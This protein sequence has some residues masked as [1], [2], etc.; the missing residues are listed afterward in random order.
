MHG[1]RND[2]GGRYSR[3][4]RVSSRSTVKTTPT[5]TATANSRAQLK[6]LPV[7]PEATRAMMT[8]NTAQYRSC[9]DQPG[10]RSVP[11]TRPVLP[12]VRDGHRCRGRSR[13]PATVARERRSTPST[14]S[15]HADRPDAERAPTAARIAADALPPAWST[16]SQPSHWSLAGREVGGVDRERHADGRER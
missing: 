2:V 7:T 5:M 4:V 15:A 12:T 13:C 6:L 9:R 8:E 14:K 1:A 3:E 10:R 11:G 16:A